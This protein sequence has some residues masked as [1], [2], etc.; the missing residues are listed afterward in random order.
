MIKL[1]NTDERDPVQANYSID[2]TVKELFTKIC[3]KITKKDR[4]DSVFLEKLMREFIEKRKG[5]LE[6]VDST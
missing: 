1:P 4:K 6:E 3:T 2:R 5:V